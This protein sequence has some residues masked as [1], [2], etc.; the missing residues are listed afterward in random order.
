MDTLIAIGFGFILGIAKKYAKTFRTAPTGNI[1]SINS[2]SH[3][4][5]PSHGRSVDRHDNEAR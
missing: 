5:H 1:R 2:V 4:D 3:G